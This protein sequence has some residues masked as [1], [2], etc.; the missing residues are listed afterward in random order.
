VSI[1]KR[2]KGA[3]VVRVHPYRAQTVVTRADAETLERDLKRRRSMGELY[4]APPN[5]LGAELDGWLD[6]SSRPAR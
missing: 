1:W 4:E 2:G 5:E 6:G 3:Y